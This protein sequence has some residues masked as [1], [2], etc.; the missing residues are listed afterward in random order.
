MALNKKELSLV[1]KKLAE[2]E[3]R[4]ESYVTQDASRQYLVAI[5]KA[6]DDGDFESAEKFIKAH[7]DYAQR[8]LLKELK[9]EARDSPDMPDLPKEA[10]VNTTEQVMSDSQSEQEITMEKKNMPDSNSAGMRIL[11][12]I[13][14]NFSPEEKS[15]IL[16]D[17]KAQKNSAIVREINKLANELR[18][19]PESYGNGEIANKIRK[20]HAE[21]VAPKDTVTPLKEDKMSNISGK[22]SAKKKSSLGILEDTEFDME[23]MK[24][25]GEELDSFGRPKGVVGEMEYYTREIAPIIEGRSKETPM[26]RRIANAME[27]PP[28]QTSF[29]G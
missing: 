23:E 21:V 27:A 2:K 11:R 18:K 1:E 25:R 24:R 15:K 14:K 10:P 20:A 22:T 4:L 19:D 13:N 8:E 26:F 9:D 17:I 16:D 7:A 3:K 12:I 5:K 28:A 6:I 29:S